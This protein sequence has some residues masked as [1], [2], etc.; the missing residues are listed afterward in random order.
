MP[1]CPVRAENLCQQAI[2]MDYASGAVAPPDTEVVRFGEAIW[3]WAERR[4]LVQ[5][6]VWPVRAVE[7]LVA[8]HR[9]FGGEI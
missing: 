1:P 2:F 3:Q 6:A 5:G 8:F 9:L 4:S 7:V